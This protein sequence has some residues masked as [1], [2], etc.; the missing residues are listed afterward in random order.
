MREKMHALNL[1]KVLAVLLVINSHSDILFPERLRLL[2]TGG[3]L[4]NSIFFI[5]SGYFTKNGNGNWKSIM[6]RFCRLYIPVYIVLMLSLFTKYINI[7]RIHNISSFVE[8]F[9]WPTPYWFVSASFVCFILF[10]IIKKYVNKQHILIIFVIIL[11][12]YIMCYIWGLP[13]KRTFVVEEGKIFNWNIH[14]KCI[15]CFGL[16]IIGYFIKLHKLIISRMKAIIL[17]ITSFGLTYGIKISMK[18]G[19]I[20]MQLQFMTQFCVICFAIGALMIAIG[21]EKSFK[22]S[23]RKML[24]LVDLFSKISLEAY[25]VQMVL[26]PV[27]AVKVNLIFPVNYV[28]ALV[29]IIMF[30]FG[31]NYIDN[32]LLKAIKNLLEEH[33]KMSQAGKEVF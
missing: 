14:F 25:V 11:T 27:I 2:A 18:E 13:D 4:G 22:N 1:L 15:Y 29:F 28:L 24:A 8:V 20:P 26:I 5:L 23:N 21:Y 7:M 19:L 12:I 17:A 31:L 33:S 30:S 6:I 10:E 32:I 16:Y 3:A 9:I